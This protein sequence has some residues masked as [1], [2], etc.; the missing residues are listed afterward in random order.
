MRPQIQL[1]KAFNMLA[2]Q[3]G[4]FCSQGRMEEN[5]FRRSISQEQAWRRQLPLDRIDRSRIGQGVPFLYR[6][7]A[8]GFVT[9]AHRG[10]GQRG[11]R[12]GSAA[13]I[14]WPT[15]RNRDLGLPF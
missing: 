3:A 1:W 6:R 5:A 13:A 9:E 8:S 11:Y 15:I 2:R 14:K 10:F 12:F 7:L 4:G